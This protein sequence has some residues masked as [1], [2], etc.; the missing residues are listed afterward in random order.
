MSLR[1]DLSDVRA[2]ARGAFLGL[3]VGDARIPIAA[4]GDQLVELRRPG[5]R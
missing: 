5:C 1:H 2:R 3:A 4:R